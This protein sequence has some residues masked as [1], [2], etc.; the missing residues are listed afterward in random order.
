MSCGIPNI[1][2][3]CS[4]VAVLASS[5]AYAQQPT[6]GHHS[7]IARTTEAPIVDETGLYIVDNDTERFS[8]LGPV[9]RAFVIKFSHM[10][11]VLN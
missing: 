6:A 3:F 8:G 4:A 11:D 2:T 7:P 1:P 5:A 10:L 9:S